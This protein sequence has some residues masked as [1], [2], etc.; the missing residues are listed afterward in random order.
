M[1]DTA[2]QLRSLIRPEGVL[3][4][5][6]VDVPVPRPAADEVLVRMEA[7][8][9]NPSDIGLLLGPAD[10]GTVE[11]GGTADRPVLTARIA[12]KAMA[13]IAGRV[14]V[15]LP[16]GIE[17]AGTVVAAGADERAQALTGRRVAAPGGSAYSQYRCVRVDDLLV[18]PTDASAAD[19]ASC[20]VNPLT[21]LG[22]VETMRR[23]G[24]R[25]IVHTAAASNLGQMLN[26]ICLED[27][28]GLVN[29]VRREEQAA[30]LRDAGATHACVS[31]DD[32]FADALDDAIAATGAT[33]GFDAIGGG[34]MAWQILSAMESAAL[35]GQP[36]TYSRY[37]SDVF[38]QVYLY[39]SLEPG[40]VTLRR[41]VGHAWS[42]GGWL[43]FPR[44]A[45]FGVATTQRMKERVA[46]GLR[47]TF[48][49]HYAQRIALARMLDPGV[50]ADFSRRATG[51]KFLV[52]PNG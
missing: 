52:E 42:I 51:T 40:P 6:L 41:N 50:L 1:E 20:F 23:E 2:M 13:S 36:S 49:S 21:A 26:R 39:G 44:L 37:G 22:M 48:R 47:T 19:G 46:A 10:L 28:I 31:S 25:A 27:G 43:L 11:T 14:G 17:G 29:V 15:S 5:S 18:L 33:I 3:E 38:K 30:L 4:L 45:R 12:P 24:H 16:V 7:A 8:P 32:A 35:R 34:T 9:I